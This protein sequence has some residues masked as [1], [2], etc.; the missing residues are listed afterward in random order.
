[1][2]Y[3]CGIIRFLSD[4]RGPDWDLSFAQDRVLQGNITIEALRAEVAKL[5][6]EL[7]NRKKPDDVRKLRK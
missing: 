7:Q 6:A 5:S 1:M 2:C 3:R 4:R